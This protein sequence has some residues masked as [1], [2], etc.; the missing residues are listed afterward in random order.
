MKNF[1]TI[2]SRYRLTRLALLFS[3]ILSEP[4][5]ILLTML[6]FILLKDLGASSWQISLVISLRPTMSILSFYWNDYQTR[7]RSNPRISLGIAGVLARLPFLFIF[8]ASTPGY[9]I[10]A[11]AVFMLFSRAGIPPWIEILKRNLTKEAREHLFSLGTMVGYTEGILLGVGIGLLL[12]V[13]HNLWKI[14]F[15]TSAVIGLFGVLLQ[16]RVPLIQ[17]TTYVKERFLSN[18]SLR[19]IFLRPWQESLHLM[20]TKPAFAQFQWGSMVSGAGI[21]LVMAVLPI[22]FVKYLQLSH[23][24]FST[25]RALCMALGVVI[26][27]SFWGKAMG[28]YSFASI[29]GVVIL[30]FALFPA[31]LLLSS[32]EIAFLYIAYILYGIAQGGSHIVWHLSGPLFAEKEDSSLYSGVNVMMVGLRGMIFPFLGSLLCSFTGPL[33]VLG[34]G[35]LFCLYGVYFMFARKKSGECE[36]N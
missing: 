23:T 16:Y 28:R 12:D 11:T 31:S 2:G 30:F 34:L 36:V 33:V 24:E 17:E 32:S 8:W 27:S 22:F 4:F 35:M 19:K 10:F 1:S 5:T 3:S 9:L 6:P 20:R 13:D 21:M 18:M 29:T 26:S 14:L 25:A 7:H 15:F